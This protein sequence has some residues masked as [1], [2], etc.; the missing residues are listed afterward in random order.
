MVCRR[1]SENLLTKSPGIMTWM[2]KNMKVMKRN[3]FSTLQRVC[4][5]MYF[6][7]FEALYTNIFTDSNLTV[8]KKIPTIGA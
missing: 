1:E 7:M 5:I 6:I 2:K 3:S 4:L 8:N